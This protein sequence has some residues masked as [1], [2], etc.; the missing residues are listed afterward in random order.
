ME[1][2]EPSQNS[3]KE[4]TSDD[5]DDEKLV[6]KDEPL[7][8]QSQDEEEV[9]V[10]AA[11]SCDYNLSQFKKDE[12]QFSE[13]EESQEQDDVKNESFEI[14]QEEESDEDVPL[15]C[16]LLSLYKS[17]FLLLMLIIYTVLLLFCRKLTEVTW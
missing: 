11:S 3:F 6:I 10:S 17:L 4:E 13:G 8:P 7:E 16:I 9:N 5:D 14:K 12:S 2:I 15:V 1:I